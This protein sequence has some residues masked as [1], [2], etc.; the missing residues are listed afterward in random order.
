MREPTNRGEPGEGCI[1]GY[2]TEEGDGVSF[3]C[4]YKWLLKPGVLP[5]GS[6]ILGEEKLQREWREG[7]ARTASECA[8]WVQRRSWSL[9]GRAWRGRGGGGKLVR[10]RGGGGDARA[11]QAPYPACTARSL[12]SDHCLPS[13]PCR[14]FPELQV[15]GH[16]HWEERGWKEA[17]HWGGTGPACAD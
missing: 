1:G 3:Y 2:D 4:S 14:A 17:Q 11:H 5:G 9:S 10:S 8:S 7:K 16:L 13:P 15:H 6:V 12:I